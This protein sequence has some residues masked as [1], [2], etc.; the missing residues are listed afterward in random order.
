M[1]PKNVNSRDHCSLSTKL[2][3]DLGRYLKTCPFTY[4]QIKYN[5]AL[6][7]VD[8]SEFDPKQETNSEQIT[9]EQMYV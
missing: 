7:L 5:Q 8:F 2:I 3:E 4:K 1:A 6:E 9:S